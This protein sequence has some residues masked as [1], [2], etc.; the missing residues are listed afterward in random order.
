M[1]RLCTVETTLMEL[2]SKQS[3]AKE[4]S[5]TTELTL[6]PIQIERTEQHESMRDFVQHLIA[7]RDT[8]GRIVAPHNDDITKK[9]KIDVA[10]FSGDVSPKVFVDWLDSL[11]D[12]FAWY[13]M[14]DEQWMAFTK[15]KLTVLLEFGGMV[16]K[17]MNLH[18]DSPL[19]DGST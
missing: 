6:T 11:E 13:G 14:N 16:L 5:S 10:D 2:Q 7:E 3:V 17:I 12:Y 19:L 18:Q 4:G 9:V 15:V 8:G 1:D